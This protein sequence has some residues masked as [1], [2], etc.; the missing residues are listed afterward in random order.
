MKMAKPDCSEKKWV[1]GGEEFRPVA[2]QIYRALVA[3]LRRERVRERMR[4]G[5]AQAH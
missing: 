5:M 4:G 2:R 1:V 3:A